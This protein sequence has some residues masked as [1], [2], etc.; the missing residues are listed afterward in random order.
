VEIVAEPSDA[1]ACEEI[2]FGPTGAAITLQ[3]LPDEAP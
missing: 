2:T 3:A 1:S